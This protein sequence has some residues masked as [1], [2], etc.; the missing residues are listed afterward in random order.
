MSN[1]ISADNN[2]PAFRRG[3]T[4]M[5]YRVFYDADSGRC[6]HK[7][8]DNVDENL[9]YILVDSETYNEIDFCDKFKVSDGKLERTKAVVQHKRLS[10]LKNQT[11][12]FRTIKNN[13][14][15]V[16]DN[17]FAGNTDSWDYYKDDQ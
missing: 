6:T 4:A 11:G 2:R 15:F 3:K 12:R 16:V 1:F 17:N 5:S 9:P 10:Q 13:M 14:L 8:C 7:T